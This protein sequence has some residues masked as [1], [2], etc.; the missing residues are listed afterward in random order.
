MGRGGCRDMDGKVKVK[1]KRAKR[2]RGRVRETMRELY[3]G[4]DWG[5]S[6]DRP[7]VKRLQRL[8][9]LGPSE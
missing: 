9:V 1:D 6:P 7:L 8:L 4:I 3:N 5:G 2:G